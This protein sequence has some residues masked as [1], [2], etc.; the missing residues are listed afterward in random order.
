MQTELEPATY[1]TENLR[2]IYFTPRA[3]VGLHAMKNNGRVIVIHFRKIHHRISRSFTRDKNH[4]CNSLYLFNI[5]TF[6]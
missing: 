2:F 1:S 4:K 3:Q 5:I 6:V